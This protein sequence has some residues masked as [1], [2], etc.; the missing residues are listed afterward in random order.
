MK[1]LALTSIP[2]LIKRH[3]SLRSAARNTGIANTTLLKHQHDYNCEQHIIVNGQ[4][5]FARNTTPK[6]MHPVKPKIEPKYE[7]I[8]N[9][10]VRI[11]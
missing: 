6:L 8:D 2:E 1:E 9:K 5:M 4:I 3:G 10:L 7:F 11:Q